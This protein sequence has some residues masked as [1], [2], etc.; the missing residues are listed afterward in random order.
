MKA[1]VERARLLLQKCCFDAWL[2]VAEQ[3][4]QQRCAERLQE[5]RCLCLSECFS[6]WRIYTRRINDMRLMLLDSTS[7]RGAGGSSVPSTNTFFSAVRVT[8]TSGGLTT[9]EHFG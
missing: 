5:L 4:Q 3:Q 9:A 1:N 7:S 6:A 2:G 8:S